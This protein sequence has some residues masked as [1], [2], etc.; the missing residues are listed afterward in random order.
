MS[1]GC[2][3]KRR[4]SG[5]RLPSW[6]VDSMEHGVQRP[7]SWLIWLWGDADLARSHPVNPEI[8][9][10]PPNKSESK[11]TKEL[12]VEHFDLR[13]WIPTWSNLYIHMSVTATAD[14]WFDHLSSALHV[15]SGGPASTRG[16]KL[17][18]ARGIPWDPV[19][20]RVTLSILYRHVSTA[21]V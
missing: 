7:S 20:S 1:P 18:M 14:I 15:A 2:G 9:R 16:S 4:L 19:G 12:D 17:L 11:E 5:T 10:Q 6:R 3:P 13:T 8:C 21:P